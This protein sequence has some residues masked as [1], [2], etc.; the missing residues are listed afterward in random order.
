MEPDYNK[1]G[2]QMKEM[3]E[4]FKP[5]S[6]TDTYKEND[7][8]LAF[9]VASKTIG[10]NIKPLKA[11]TEEEYAAWRKEEEEKRKKWEE[12]HPEEV[13]KWKAY[14]NKKASKKPYTLTPEEREIVKELLQ[15]DDKGLDELTITIM[16]DGEISAR[17]PEISWKVLAG[18]E[19]WINLKE[20]K[21]R[22]VCFS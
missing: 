21:H 13:A 2:N 8:K 12:E 20:K 11:Q 14:E 5:K 9:E 17:T 15:T 4:T 19:W 18:R 3:F 1:L 7:L 22:C 10:F 6:S 16:N